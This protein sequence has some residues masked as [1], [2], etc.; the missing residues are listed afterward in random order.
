LKD[1]SSVAGLEAFIFHDSRTPAKL[2]MMA[3]STLGALETDEAARTLTNVVSDT[4]LD[5]AVRRSALQALT[6]KLSDAGRRGLKQFASNAASHDPL[7]TE[8]LK[9]LS[10]AQQSAAPKK[11]A[12]ASATA[13]APASEELPSLEPEELP[14]LE[15]TS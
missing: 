4:E 12:A 1:P 6:S 8:V 11:A 3:T 2:L 5:V 7:S 15:P 13:S 14:P 10:R 9:A